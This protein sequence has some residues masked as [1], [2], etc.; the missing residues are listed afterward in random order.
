M[1]QKGTTAEW[2]ES[3]HRRSEETESLSFEKGPGGKGGDDKKR[4]PLTFESTTKVFVK[5]RRGNPDSRREVRTKVLRLL[6]ELV[7]VDGCRECFTK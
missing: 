5:T 3:R 2:K 4:V 1:L 6:R 7:S